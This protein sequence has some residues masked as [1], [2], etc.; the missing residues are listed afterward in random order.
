VLTPPLSPRRFYERALETTPDA[1]AV[2]DAL[3]ELLIGLGEGERAQ[4]LLERSAKL[5]PESGSSKWLYLGQMSEGWQALQHFSKGAELLKA[6]LAARGRVGMEGGGAG[7]EVDDETYAIMN[8]VVSAQCSIAELYLTDLC[9]ED[10]AESR[11]QAALDEAMRMD[12]GDSPEVT[13]ALANLRLS[14]QKGVEAAELML[15]T[16]RRL[17]ACQQEDAEEGGEE[18]E[19]EEGKE[20]GRGLPLP[21]VMFRVQTA[22]LL[23][24]CQA[25]KNGKKCAKRA[26]KVLEACKCEDDENMEVWYLLGVAYFTQS[27]PDLAMAKAHLLYAQGVMR[28]LQ[29]QQQQQEGKG[30]EEEEGFEYEDH[31]RLVKEQLA[32]V[33]DAEANG[34]KACEE[35]AVAAMEEED[36]EGGGSSS[37]SSS[38]D[39]SSGVEEEEEDEGGDTMEN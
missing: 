14:Q 37:S 25:Y 22:K 27:K 16:V 28:K 7:E 39:E 9:Y 15:E 17:K 34:I 21:N 1:T 10:D 6:E 18:E 20:G 13:Q 2:M 3:A 32:M 36:G 31:L 23:L 38:S 5:A 33:V 26:I 12:V 24:E 30:G 11:C 8:Q 19:E 29:Q 35:E 4:A